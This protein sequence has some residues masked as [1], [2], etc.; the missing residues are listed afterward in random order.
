MEF[1]I[2]NNTLKEAINRLS[3]LVDKKSVIPALQGIMFTVDDNG[4]TLKSSSLESYAT[5]KLWNTMKYDVQ[6]IEHGSVVITLPDV[7][8]I[9]MVK[10][11]IRVKSDGNFVVSA[12]NAKK[13]SKIAGIDSKE[14]IDFPAVDCNSD[15][16]VM[17]IADGRKFCEELKIVGESRSDNENKPI[18]MGFNFR[19]DNKA[20]CALDGFRMIVKYMDGFADNKFNITIAGRAEKELT[21]LIGKSD[22]EINMYSGKSTSGVYFAVFVGS[23]FEY[24][25]RLLDGEFLDYNQC[26]IKDVANTR[27]SFTDNKGIIETLKEYIKFAPKGIGSPVIMTNYNGELL[28]HFGTQNYRTNDL[29][30][31]EGWLDDELFIGF[32]PNYM[33]GMIKLFD[34][35]GIDYNVT[36]HSALKPIF[37][38]GGDYICLVVPMRV[39]E[40]YDRES[41]IAD[42]VA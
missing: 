21:K 11:L 4:L 32:N 6:I 35:L 17:T 3:A 22:Y 42:F 34:K 8:K 1:I 20:V 10:D 27:F 26:I 15:N 14:F 7:E 23:D 5:I 28:T 19:S 24:M 9:L 29:H 38:T 18:Y 13:K 2:D 36:I 39:K 41:I 30:E 33:L 25:V 12:Q 31:I 16:L 37:I 40:E